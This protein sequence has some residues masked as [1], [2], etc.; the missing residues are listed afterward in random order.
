MRRLVPG[1]LLFLVFAAALEAG[2]WPNW[3]GPDYNG[4][5][6][7][8]GYPT[9]WSK[10]KNVQWAYKIPGKGSSTP[11][12]FGDRIVLTCGIDGHNG[13]VC[14][15][16]KGKE[17]WTRKEIGSEKPGKHKKATG[18][19]SSPCTDGKYIYAYF[20]SGDLACLDMSGAV[21]WQHNLQEMYGEDT[22]WWDLGTSPVLTNRYVVV[23]VMQTGPSFLVAFEKGTG[24]VAWK[25]DR[26]LPAPSE[27]AQSY[28][29]PLV[30]MDEGREILVVSGA[31]YVTAHETVGGAE[32]WRVGSLNPKQNGFFRSIASPVA[33]DGVVLAPYA[34]GETLTAIRLGGRGDVTSTNVIWTK[35]FPKPEADDVPT[36]AAVEG[37]A[38]VCSDRGMLTCF[39]VQSGKV[40]WSGMAEKTGRFN[41]SSSPTVVDGKIYITREDG[42]TFVLRQ[43][44][45]F[46]VLAANELEEDPV[47]ATPVPVDGKLLIRT[48]EHLYCIGN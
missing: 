42:K 44:D 21:L 24:K 36:P 3:R 30:L 1:L 6:A 34:R 43:G 26:I 17:L 38:Y 4:V 2:D 20:K 46:E 10:T 48:A 16:R 35:Q 23:A 32:L 25:Q 13:V 27:A 28:T 8:K 37:R 22:L 11:I 41:F 47:V 9:E 29:T 14:L 5:G 18:S 15:E 7:G 12:V 31:D 19:N 33:S 40:L 39:D 45:K